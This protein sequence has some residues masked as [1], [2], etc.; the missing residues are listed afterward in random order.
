MRRLAALLS[1]LLTAALPLGARVAPHAA[2]LGGRLGSS[3][4]GVVSVL[5]GGAV[6]GAAAL[7]ACAKASKAGASHADDLLR[8]GSHTDDVLRVGT[9]ADDAARA[10]IHADGVAAHADD[11][12][13][14][15]TASSAEEGG[16]VG[17]HVAQEGA[18]RAAEQAVGEHGEDDE[19]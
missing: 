16:T 11:A 12:V 4:S 14:A 17:E 1:S 3:N 13:T 15:R 9:H 6:V 2:R 10:G 19:E 8:A 7:R 18:Q 5:G